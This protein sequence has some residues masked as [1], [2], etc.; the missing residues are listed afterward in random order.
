MKVLKPLKTI[1]LIIAILFVF[2]SM[3]TPPPEPE[4]TAE[5]RIAAALEY[6]NLLSM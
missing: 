2:S 6:Q 1:C 5:E 4:P 3:N